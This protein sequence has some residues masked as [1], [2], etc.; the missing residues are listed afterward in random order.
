MTAFR[1]QYLA[2]ALL[3][4]GLQRRVSDIVVVLTSADIY[5]GGLKYIFGLAT[6]GS[7]MISSARIDPA[8]WKCI[9]DIFRYTSEGRRFFESQYA[10]VLV[11]ELGH[12]FGLYHCND[13]DCAMHYSNSPIELY[14]KGEWYCQKCLKKFALSLAS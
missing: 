9:Q 3:Q 10:K 5:T 8:F 2:D 6:R 1:K 7:A 11:H 12:A 13:C 4:A 14:K